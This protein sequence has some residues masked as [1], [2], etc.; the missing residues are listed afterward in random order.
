MENIQLHNEIA[1][2]SSNSFRCV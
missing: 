1:F 2:P